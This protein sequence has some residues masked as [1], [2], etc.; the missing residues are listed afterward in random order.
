[1]L[2]VNLLVINS[3]TI[4]YLPLSFHKFMFNW[5][6]Q[7]FSSPTSTVISTDESQDKILILE[8]QLQQ[9]K[10]ELEE[11]NKTINNLQQQLQRQEEKEFLQLQEKILGEKEKLFNDIA[12]PISQLITQKYLLEVE[13]KPVQAKDI[14]LVVKRLINVFESQGLTV[15]GDMGKTITF[16]PNYHQ[17]LINNIDI[18]ISDKVI[19][20]IVGVS[21]QGQVIK[22]AIVEKIND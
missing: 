16:N 5:L 3:K 22:K 4:T 21:Y 15:I 17:S 7:L 20:K 13:E 14:L 2:I 10:L 8:T 18:N 12:S 1:M 9:L 6:K 19:I 11:G